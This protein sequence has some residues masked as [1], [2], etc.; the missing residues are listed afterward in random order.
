[1]SIIPEKKDVIEF[2]EFYSNVGSG[3][4]LIHPIETNDDLRQEIGLPIEFTLIINAIMIL[5]KIIL[6]NIEKYILN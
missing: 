4:N 1:M 6:L 3:V 2:G 5:K